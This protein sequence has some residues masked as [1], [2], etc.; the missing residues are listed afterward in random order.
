MPTVLFTLQEH[1]LIQ[2]ETQ[3]TRLNGCMVLGG[4]G[5]RQPKPFVYAGKGEVNLRQPCME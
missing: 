5:V 3:A 2:Y 4:W 1:P